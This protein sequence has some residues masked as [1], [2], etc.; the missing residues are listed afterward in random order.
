[1][2]A[3]I[4]PLYGV[5]Y[6]ACL[7]GTLIG[8]GSGEFLSFFLTTL[9]FIVMILTFR[10]KNQ[11]ETRNE[12]QKMGIHIFAATLLVQLVPMFFDIFLW[13]DLISA[14]MLASMT[15][16]FYKIF[17]NSISVIT[18]FGEKQAFSIEEVIGASLLITIAFASLASLT[19]FG[20]SITNIL[21]IMVVLFLGWKNGMLAGGTA[22]ITIGVVLGLITEVNPVIIS[23]FAISRNVGSEY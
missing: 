6:A 13:Y 1:M 18:L 16:I 19:I 5:V 2:R 22:G 14:F 3:V 9:V 20:L 12:K 11:D 23:S 7:I 10:P 17:V 4:K 15:Y 21:S 8:F